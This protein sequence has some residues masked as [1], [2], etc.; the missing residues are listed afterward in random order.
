MK[1]ITGVDASGHGFEFQA[2]AIDGFYDAYMGNHGDMVVHG[3]ATS[4]RWDEYLR[5]R[6]EWRGGV[7]APA[8][9]VPLAV[10]PP[11]PALQLPAPPIEP[12]RPPRLPSRT[13]RR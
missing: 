1:T 2:D 5:L 10:Q 7:A 6:D 8:T 11:V 12:T 9:V 13:T 4:L 3:R